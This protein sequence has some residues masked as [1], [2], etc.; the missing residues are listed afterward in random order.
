[1]ALAPATISSAG[2]PMKTRV[3]FHCDFSSTRVRAAPSQ[4]AMWTSWPQLCIT[5]VSRPSLVARAR[6]AY[7][8][9][10]C[11]SIGRPSMSVRTRTVGPA[12]FLSTAT[13]PVLPTFSV[14]VKPSLRISPAS[15][16]AV[17]TSWKAISGWACKSL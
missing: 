7:G 4:L 1:M 14:T 17:R 16:P 9:P 8:R 13:M 2:W 11:S 10:V 15:L 6:L 3:P 12:P 5:K